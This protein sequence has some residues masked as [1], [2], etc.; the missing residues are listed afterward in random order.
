MEFLGNQIARAR[1]GNAPFLVIT[2]Y[3]YKNRSIKGKLVAFNREDIAQQRADAK[4]MIMMLRDAGYEIPSL[5][6]S[7]I[8]ADKPLDARLYKLFSHGLIP[9]QSMTI[10]ELERIANLM[11][12]YE[13]KQQA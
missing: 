12:E 13:S 6:H 2:S 4:S 11:I 8:F 9:F 7:I 5:W 3:D 1:K 10:E